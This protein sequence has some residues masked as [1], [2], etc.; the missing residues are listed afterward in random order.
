[1]SLW[2]M[3]PWSETRIALRRYPEPVTVGLPRPLYFHLQDIASEN[4][5]TVPETIR[6]ACEALAARDALLLKREREDA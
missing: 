6:V 3:N 1:M 2:S 5:W 4:G